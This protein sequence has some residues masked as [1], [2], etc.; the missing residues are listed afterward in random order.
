MDQSA[1]NFIYFLAVIGGIVFVIW[2]A[3]LLW[4]LIK[5]ILPAKNFS[6]RYGKRSWAVITGGSDG[7]GLGFCE[8]LAELGFNICMVARNREKMEAALV[9]IK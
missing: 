4:A 1:L 3:K 9:R 8:E 7:I 5:A 2:I 6:E